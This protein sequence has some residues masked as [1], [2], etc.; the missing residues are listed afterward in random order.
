VEQTYRL[1]IRGRLPSVVREELHQRFSDA[2]V[3]FDGDRT[4]VSGLTA[5]QAALRAV[6]SLLWDLGSEVQLVEAITLPGNG[7]E[8][9]QS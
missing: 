9:V 2:Q 5:D 4:V 8:E 6:L 3:R 1:E 7:E